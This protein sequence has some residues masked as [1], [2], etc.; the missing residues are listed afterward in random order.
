MPGTTPLGI[1]YPLQNETVTATSWQTMATD[2]DT[3]LSSLDTIRDKTTNPTTA[4]I[5]GP[6]ITPFVTLATATDGTYNVFDTVEWDNG[7]L[8][9]LGVNPDRLTLQSGVYFARASVSI[10]NYTTL[11]YMRV[12][13]LCGGVIWSMQTTSTLST[14][15]QLTS[16]ASGLVV[17]TTPPLPLQM[18][19]RWVGTGGP[20]HFIQG[21]LQVYKI[22]DIANV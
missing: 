19:I 22:R 8:A 15:P 2:I 16:A 13:L 5:R 20:A 7:G 14:N 18:R 17:V 11:T 10:T 3:L 6:F 9:S 12:G 4:S 1:H 21:H